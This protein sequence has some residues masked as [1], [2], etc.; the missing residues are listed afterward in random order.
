M[1]RSNLL[2][3]GGAIA[4]T[5]WFIWSLVADK[6]T[7]FDPIT[8]CQSGKAQ[9][10]ITVLIDPSTPFNSSQQQQFQRFT[11]YLQQAL[12]E[13]AR[14]NST[15]LQPRRQCRTPLFNR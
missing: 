5:S 8:H 14:L 10:T 13:N 4:L 15:V 6:P 9:P 7:T 11:V 12:P 2:Y 1:N 3:T